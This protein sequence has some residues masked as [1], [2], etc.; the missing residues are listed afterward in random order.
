M[1]NRLLITSVAVLAAVSLNAQFN[2]T[3]SAGG[4]VE[5]GGGRS[6]SD[7]YG[8]G[9]GNGS[10]AEY[11]VMSF[12]PT[13]GDFGG[14][15]TSIESVSYQ[16]TH[17]DRTFS[18][19]GNIE[20]FFTTD[21]FANDF[22]SLSYDGAVVNGLDA[23]QYTYAPVS[24]GTFAYTPQNGGVVDTFNLTFSASAL[25]DLLNEINAGSEFQI[26]ITGAE[27]ATS[28]TYSGLGNT[29]DP[30]DPV[31]QISATAVPEP[32]TYALLLG[33]MGLGLVLMRRRSIR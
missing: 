21:D 4:I 25:T 6:V 1:N 9:N 15:L 29:F 31:L 7:Y 26:L 13:S 22:S 19:A 28:A 10:F 30:G 12:A 33:A 27:A 16:L 5:L 14:T 18:T 20:F 23:T 24:L 17:N 3:P 32:S 8:Q 2:A 11:G